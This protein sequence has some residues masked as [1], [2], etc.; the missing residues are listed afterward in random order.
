MSERRYIKEIL[1][2]FTMS[3]CNPVSKPIS[4]GTKVLCISVD[5][6]QSTYRQQIFF[7]LLT[8]LHFYFY[9][10]L[11]STDTFANVII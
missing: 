5:R 7:Y 1:Q 11:V 4:N 8:A 10:V 3:D 6:E 2:L 9:I